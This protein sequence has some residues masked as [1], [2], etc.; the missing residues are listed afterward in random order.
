MKRSETAQIL[1]THRLHC[2]WVG[3]FQPAA[4]VER[5]SGWIFPTGSLPENPDLARF[6]PSEIEIMRLW[7]TDNKTESAKDA[8]VRNA[9]ERRP[10]SGRPGNPTSGKSQE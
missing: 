5:I 9:Q 7:M 3:Q 4:E 2:L 8:K 1:V 10:K 6:T